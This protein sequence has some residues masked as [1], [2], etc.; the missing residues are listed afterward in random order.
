MFVTVLCTHSKAKF[1]K[2]CTN[3]RIVNIITCFFMNWN[4]CDAQSKWRGDCALHTLRPYQD[5]WKDRKENANEKKI[6]C[7]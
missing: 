7:I 2:I 1:R 3:H 6:T 5:N 4:C